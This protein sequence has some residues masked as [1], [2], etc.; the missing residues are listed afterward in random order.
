[1]KI[2]KTQGFTVLE[3]M[4]VIT[5]T[6][7]LTMIAVPAV[8]DFLE[9][10]RI[11]SQMF[12]VL[13]AINTA[14][15]E[16]IK[17]KNTVT[18][19]RVADP[20]AGT[21]VCGSSAANTWTTGWFIFEDMDG[22]GNYDPG[23]GDDPIAKGNPALKTLTVITNGTSNNNLQYKP[24]GTTKE[25]GGTARFAICDDRGGTV[26]R[27]INVPPVGR[28]NLFEGKDGNA[29]DCADPDNTPVT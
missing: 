7:L 13:N 10:N 18:I 22:D 26:G 19:C 6:G 9:N 8:F 21:P 23:D 14:R 27:Q 17:R 16:A 29:V 12:E 15:S 1:M 5:I 20:D 4:V 28:A 3:L 24:D 11:K 2:Y 25:G